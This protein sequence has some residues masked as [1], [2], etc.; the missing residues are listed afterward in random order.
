[1]ELKNTRALMREKCLVI[2]RIALK[3]GFVPGSFQRVLTG[4]FE[5]PPNPNAKYWRMVRALRDEGLLCDELEIPEP[6]VVMDAM[7]RRKR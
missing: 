4:A 2:R 5:P 6:I 1:M 7:K 3:H